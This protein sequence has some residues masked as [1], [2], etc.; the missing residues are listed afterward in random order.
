[1]SVADIAI[2]RLIG[3]FTAGVIDGFPKDMI[4]SFPKLRR[5]CVAV[6]KHEQIQS[7]VQKTYPENYPRGNY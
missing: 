7:W 6:D 2:W 3:W 5:L 1:M 4:S